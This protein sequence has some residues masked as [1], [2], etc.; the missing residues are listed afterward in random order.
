MK[1]IKY[2]VF[3]LVILFASCGQTDQQ[4]SNETEVTVAS[5]SNDKGEPLGGKPAP[6]SKPSVADLDYQV[7]YQRAFEAVIWSMPAISIYGF[8]RASELIGAG[9]NVIL[10][11]SEPAK[12]NSELLTANNQVPY[13][14]SQTDLRKGPVVLEVP[15]ASETASLYGQVV[16]HWQITIAGVGPSGVDQ[17]KGG[18]ILLTPPG[19]DEPVSDEYIEI[20]SPSYRVAFA[21]RS[22]PGPNSSTA[23][24]Y[25]YAQT[26]KMYYYS[27]LP[28]PKPTQFIDPSNKRL[29]TL[30]HYDE[31]W[32]EELYEIVS[33]EEVMPRDKVMMGMLASLGIQKGKPYNPDEKTKKAM[34][35]GVVDAYFFLQQRSLHPKDPSRIW[36]SDKHW[37]NGLYSDE[38]LEFSYEYE[39]RIDL[40]GRAE[41]YFS[42]T[43]YPKKIGP[44]PATQ[45]LFA[46]ADE[47][48]EELQ[49]NKT[50][51]FTMPAE[52]PVE[53]FWSLVIYDLEV[54]AF[55]YNPLERAGLSSFDLLNM[56]K[57]SDGSVTLYFGPQ[58]PDGL[59]S[60][61]IPTEG[62]RPLPVVRFYG[63]TEEFWDKSWKM[64]DVELYKSK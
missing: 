58:P 56:Q 53:Q 16:D 37:Y 10:A 47:N 35:Q 6:G 36:W 26:L 50:Y 28:N 27:E 63:G 48:G 4:A 2:L 41:R 43:Y 44:K 17:G 22:V 59:E 39:D 40:D 24:A 45:Y 60:N 38:N 18:K 1:N 32:F 25:E 3:S 29:S 62:K 55:I 21:F 61:W 15:A 33:V 57:N 12:P 46:L 64:P 9:P 13:I 30:P 5:T 54:F 52:V 11:Y 14:L 49:A 42:G 20:K 34:K 7:K 31:R 51:S 19:Y 8:H 23:Q